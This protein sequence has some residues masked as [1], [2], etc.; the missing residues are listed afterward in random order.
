MVWEIRC[1]FHFYECFIIIEKM[2]IMICHYFSCHLLILICRD[3]MVSQGTKGYQGFQASRLAEK[4][5]QNSNKINQR[6]YVFMVM[7]L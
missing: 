6:N 7:V 2:T 3:M 5:C 1:V 4:S